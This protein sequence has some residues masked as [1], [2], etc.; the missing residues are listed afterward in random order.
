M[1]QSIIKKSEKTSWIKKIRS[2]H[3]ISKGNRQRE[4]K[5]GIAFAILCTLLWGMLPVYWKS[6]DPIDPILILFY[7]IILAFLLSL[8]MAII[9]YPLEVILRPLN[10][11]A[12]LR[13]FFI[14]GALIS[15]NWGIYIWAVSNEQIIQTSIGYYIEPLIVCVFGLL[16][17]KEKLNR[18]KLIA[19]IFAGL[20]V[21]VILIYH[22]QIPVVA[23][24]LAF[25]FGTYAAIKKK[26]RVDAVLSLLY[27]TLFLVP[28]AVAVILYYEL[29]GS[30]A[31]AN[32]E[33]MQWG[34]LALAGIVTGTPLMLF[35]M[36]ANRI[37]LITLGVT[38]YIS[39]TIGLILGIFVYREPFDMIQ[40]ITFGFI[41][42]GL[43]IFTVGEVMENR[44]IA[45]K[46]SEQ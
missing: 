46:E 20:G 17:F 25:T 32:A 6:L 34:L 35:A 5:Q 21:A 26:L 1:S 36:A 45:E 24:S 28:F 39:P 43:V 3:G 10:N 7:R 14:A 12:T 19:V 44:S 18:Y 29:T 23:L 13:T 15:L 8:I 9:F 37:S 42:V 40:L 22:G 38:G 41:W 11:K 16:F 27:E 33:P 31:Y 30:G 2:S 4:Y